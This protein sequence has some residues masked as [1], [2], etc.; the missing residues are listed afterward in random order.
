MR[1]IT[2]NLFVFDSLTTTKK[3]QN[4]LLYSQ[5]LTQKNKRKKINSCEKYAIKFTK[6]FHIKKSSAVV[7]LVQNIF[8]FPKKKKKM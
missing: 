6:T 5:Y 3:K 4:I 2:K 1:D 7:I 8:P